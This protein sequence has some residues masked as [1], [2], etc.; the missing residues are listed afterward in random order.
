[1]IADL[2]EFLAEPHLIQP[3]IIYDFPPCSLSPFRRL[4]PDVFSL[5]EVERFEFYIGGF[6][7]A[8]PSASTE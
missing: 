1:M 4:E 2:F 8:M 3:T 5:T 6:E 7:V